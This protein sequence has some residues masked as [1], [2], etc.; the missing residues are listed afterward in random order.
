MKSGTV[1]RTGNASGVMGIRARELAYPSSMSGRLPAVPGEHGEDPRARFARVVRE[2]RD[3]KGWGQDKLAE[4]SGVSRPTIQRWENARTGTPDPD[5]ARR[6]F[7]ALGLDPRLIPVVLGYVT[8]EE[9]GLPPQPPRV[10]TATVEEAIRILD[11]PQVPASAKAEWLRFLQ[12]R[13]QEAAETQARRKA[14]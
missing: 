5:N 11:D 1:Y 2:A 10:F 8:D 13:A 7:Q 14:G 3:Q 4:E 12:F 9:M 6:V